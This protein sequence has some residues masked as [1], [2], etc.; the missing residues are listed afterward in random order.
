MMKI[1]NAWIM[2][3]GILSALAITLCVFLA[4]PTVEP[5]PI[6]TN[7]TD[8]QLQIENIYNQSLYQTTDCLRNIEANLGKVCASN[9][10]IIQQKCLTKVEGYADS[11][12]M[13]LSLMPAR[14]GNSIEKS[15]KFTNQLSDYCKSLSAKLYGGKTLEDTD[16]TNLSNL[17]M[18]AKSL[19]KQITDLVEN[20]RFFMINTDENYGSVGSKYANFEDLEETTFDYPTLVYEGPYSDSVVKNQI[21]VGDEIT[22]DASK[23]IFRSA[24]EEFS[25]KSVDYVETIEN[26]AKV[27][28]FDVM[29]D[30][31]VVYRVMALLD[32]RI[33]QV[34][35]FSEVKDD[36]TTFDLDSCK[37]TAEKFANK[38]GYNVQA[39][40]ASRP[41]EGRIYVTLCQV[42]KDTIAYP[43]M[44]KVAVDVNTGRVVA[45]EG[46]S[47]LAN[48]KVRTIPSKIKNE[49]AAL[50]KLASGLEVVG[51]ARAF[52]PVGEKEYYV[53]QFECE[54]GDQK[55]FIYIDA[56]TLEERD[57][58][59]QVEGLEGFTLI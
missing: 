5:N 4:I 38:I 45:L 8:Y 15:I 35:T 13:D 42:V 41:I 26:K 50:K 21:V 37:T 1:K 2:F 49:T 10:S 59:V 24:F 22:I 14:A 25:I 58:F 28:V 31:D 43:D 44:V 57:I 56:Q 16:R 52:I 6:V 34:S 39:I 7:K 18:V 47:Y 33:A 30:N 27:R 46:Y 3:F 23:E 48:N 55:F 32:G 29:T 9:N 17:S 53:Y 54:K 19:N 40:W 11:A 12:N 20:D 36:E 51:S